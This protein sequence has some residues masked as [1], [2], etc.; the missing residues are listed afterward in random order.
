MTVLL[1][2]TTLPDRKSA[3]DLAAA[4]IEAKLAACVNIGQE[5]TSLYHW[6]GRTENA[7]EVPVTIKSTDGR[8]A[9]LEVAIRERHPY[10]LP[11]IV[12]VPVAAGLPVYLQWV[13][14]EVGDSGTPAA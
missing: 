6:R 14:D 9:Q 13:A 12:A 11:E 2:H 1:V 3:E 5:V 10:E 8:Y 4:L 7:T